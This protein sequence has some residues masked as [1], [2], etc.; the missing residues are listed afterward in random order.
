[1]NAQDA[2]R[3]ALAAAPMFA[4]PPSFQPV[5]AELRII[6][7]VEGAPVRD[8]LPPPGPVIDRSAWVVRLAQGILWAELAIDDL[9]GEV[10]RLRRSRGAAQ[11]LDGA[12]N[13]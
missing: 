12:G 2:V 4:V 8:A 7:L 1:M 3:R 9:N 5:S 11:T 13:G 6:E 10:L